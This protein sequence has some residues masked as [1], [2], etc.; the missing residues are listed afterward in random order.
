VNVA[1]RIAEAAKLYAGGLSTTQVADRMRVTRTTV[2]RWLKLAGVQTRA[3]S[4]AKILRHLGAR[5]KQSG[6]YVMVRLGKGLRRPEH[7]IIAE[8]ALGRALK[9]GEHVHHINCNPADNRNENLLIC[10]NSYH[11][12]LHWRM[13]RH[14]QWSTISKRHA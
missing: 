9:R 5:S 3:K 13:A 10:S 4:E 12:E 6:G 7:L 11:A 14:P 1:E 8:R 2:L